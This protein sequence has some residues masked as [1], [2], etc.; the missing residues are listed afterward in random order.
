MKKQI[1]LGRESI[2]HWLIA[3]A[4][5]LLAGCGGGGGGD[6]SPTTPTPSVTV[7]PMVAAGS[8]HSFA[9]KSDG[10]VVS[11]GDQENGTLG[12]GVNSAS[13]TRH[14][15]SVLGLSRITQIAA[16]RAHGLALSLDGKIFVWG[17]NGSARLGLGSDGGAVATP[18]QL[19]SLSNI[20]AV[21]AGDTHSLAL[22]SDGAIFTWGSNEAGQLGLGDTSLRMLP[23]QI[24]QLSNVKSVAAGGQH[25]LAL[26]S[27]GTVW[28][29]GNNL[30]GQLGLGDLISRTIPVRVTALAGRGTVVQLA[31]GGFHSMALMSAGTIHAWGS[32][33]YGQVGGNYGSD[34]KTPALVTGI[35]AAAE[36]SAG[37]LH[38]LTRLANGTMLSW[39]HAGAGRLGN[40]FSGVTKSTDVPQQVQ[41]AGAIAIAAGQSH[42]LA[43]MQDGR[44]ACFGDNFFSA[45]GRFE[46]I[47]FSVP[48]EVGPGLRVGP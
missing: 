2:C 17:A 27:D 23:T 28:A 42:S 30:D 12:N 39:G 14:P 35:N 11:W 25:S 7:K 6:S 8:G 20:I 22:R 18:V 24:T 10:T 40:G 21:A 38:S 46:A 15:Q 5:A 44:V 19:T 31:A 13:S 37:E 29:W 34:V 32:S 4:M 9:L 3:G 36:I 26:R 33:L 1:F 45:C 47:D 41:L 16:G 43:V 48:V